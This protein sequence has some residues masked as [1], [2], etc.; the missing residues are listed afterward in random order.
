MPNSTQRKTRKLAVMDMANLLEVGSGTTP[1]GGRRH[2]VVAP[3]L[4][5]MTARQAP[6]GQPAAAQAAVCCDRL[7]CVLR[8]RGVEAT[9]R[10]E[11]RADAQLIS[12]DQKAKNQA[13]AADIFCQICC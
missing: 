6:E 10:P 13:H 1:T 4:K 11:Q 9:A 12:A 3:V 7:Q 2:R 8:A 5:R